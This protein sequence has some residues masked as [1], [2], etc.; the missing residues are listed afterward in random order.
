MKNN[1]IWCFIMHH[2]EKYGDSIIMVVL[3]DA[4]ESAGT[5]G[6]RNTYAVFGYGLSGY[7]FT[8]LQLKESLKD[9]EKKVEETKN[10]NVVYECHTLQEL[11][12]KLSKEQRTTFVTQFEEH[13]GKN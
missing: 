11:W 7:Q 4:P 13:F 10:G 3:I 2:S 5:S 1:E 6:Q 9:F 12:S 8:Y